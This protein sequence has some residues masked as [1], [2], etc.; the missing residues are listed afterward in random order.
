MADCIFCR[1]VKG[2][3]PSAKLF[4]TKEILA[5]LDIAPAARGHALVIP[6]KHFETLLDIPAGE[7]RETI[8]AVKQVARAVMAASDA[9]GF[10]IIQSNKKAA[11][12]VIP[13]LHF[14]IVPRKQDDALTFEWAR[15]E[16][17]KEELE[18]LKKKVKSHLK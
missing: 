12:Q 5:F 10:N 18:I 13:H 6:K 8:V 14:H 16:L 4:E 2:E 3:I 15:I 11:G 17:D 9:D 1:I 7:L